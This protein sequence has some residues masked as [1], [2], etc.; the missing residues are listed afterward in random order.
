MPP[1]KALETQGTPDSHPNNPMY[2][3]Q[4]Q[5]HSRQ[6]AT[7]FNGAKDRSYPNEG[8]I[9]L[10]VNIP[11]HEGQVNRT[12]SQP[13]SP[14]GE[15]SPMTLKTDRTA[16]FMEAQT[17][18][19]LSYNR[20][21]NIR[22]KKRVPTWAEM[23]AVFSRF[24]GW[25]PPVEKIMRWNLA[26]QYDD[27]F[28]YDKSFPGRRRDREEWVSPHNPSPEL[29]AQ[30]PGL[31]EMRKLGPARRDGEVGRW[32]AAAEKVINQVAKE[33]LEAHLCLD[34]REL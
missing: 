13:C 15:H 32:T 29:L 14:A 1:S 17:L 10:A 6:H 27:Q 7:H 34:P 3:S 31:R 2:Y 23:A 25:A 9:P 28:Y 30:F 19:V 8:N 4:Q 12:L 11:Y 24:H 5:Q 22:T 20:L 33:M 26:F 18:D 16:T 21:K